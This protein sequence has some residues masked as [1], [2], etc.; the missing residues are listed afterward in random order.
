MAA[1]PK[2]VCWDACAW[3]ALIQKE[4]IRNEAGALIE[5]RYALCRSVI[6][7]AEKNKV[8]IVSSGLCLAEVSKNPPGSPSTEDR[9]G[10]YFEHDFVVVAP[11][12]TNV[13]TRARQLLVANHAGLRKPQDAVHVATALIANADELHTFDD[14]LLGLDGKL[15]KAD[16]T[17]L[18]I[19]RPAFGG[20]ALPLLD[21]LK[22]GEKT[23]DDLSPQST[24]ETPIPPEA[25]VAADPE[26]PEAGA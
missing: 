23:A 10:A 9:V 13:G 2:R 24:P 3:I 8:E 17:M 6:D 18:K 5:D 20:N 7:M 4:R 15:A 14:K 12:D 22:P 11:V 21:A 25:T 1:S 19:C 26:I 16:G